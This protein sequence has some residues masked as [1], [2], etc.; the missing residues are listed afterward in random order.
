ML[1][2]DMVE[3]GT[4]NLSVEWMQSRTALSPRKEVAMLAP[5][6]PRC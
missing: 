6:V 5:N 1:V 2:C 4:E 3:E